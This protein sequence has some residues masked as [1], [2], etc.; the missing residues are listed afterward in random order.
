MAEPRSAREGRA[1]LLRQRTGPRTVPSLKAQQENQRA[2]GTWANGSHGH[3]TAGTC[4]AEQHT[5][6]PLP[7]RP[8]GDAR[9]DAPDL[10]L[11]RLRPRAARKGR[12][13]RRCGSSDD[14]D[15]CHRGPCQRSRPGAAPRNEPCA[16]GLRGAGES[17][18]PEPRE[19]LSPCP[20][21]CRTAPR[22]GSAEPPAQGTVLPSGTLPGD[23]GPTP[24]SALCLRAPP[25]PG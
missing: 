9:P 8:L 7:D 2:T 5:E 17:G 6:M 15:R 23:A 13:R 14:S 21:N 11:E 1:R 19:S 22:Q 20:P 3:R 24:S 16:R 25:R 10:G 18:A 4:T 12:G